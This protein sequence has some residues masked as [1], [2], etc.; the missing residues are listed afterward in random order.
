MKGMM[1]T[2]NV[3]LRPGSQPQ[4]KDDNV[5]AA[6]RLTDRERAHSILGTET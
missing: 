3:W 4:K 5:Q 2:S 6:A 1:D